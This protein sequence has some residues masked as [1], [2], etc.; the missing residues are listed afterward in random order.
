MRKT[1][2]IALAAVGIAAALRATLRSSAP[3]AEAVPSPA[4]FAEGVVSTPDDEFGA[5]FTPNAKTVYFT[6]RTPTTNTPPLSFICVSRMR[7]GRWQE[8]E[9]A[10]FSGEHNDLGPALSPD[11]AR[12][13]FASDRPM[14]GAPAGAAARARQRSSPPRPPGR[15]EAK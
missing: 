10:A 1:L 15:V 6:K 4:L 13:F 7:D 12:L 5:A 3:P 8:P 14:P 9:I 2:A 11:G